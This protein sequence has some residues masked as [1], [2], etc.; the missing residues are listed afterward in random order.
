MFYDLIEF[1]ELSNSVFCSK[2]K[3]IELFLI[4]ISIDFYEEKDIDLWGFVPLSS[5]NLFNFQN[6]LKC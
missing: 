5:E 6:H 4:V 3:K 2:V 1:E